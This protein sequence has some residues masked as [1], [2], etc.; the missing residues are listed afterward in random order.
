MSSAESVCRFAIFIPWGRVGSNL[1]MEII[2]QAGRAKLENEKFNTLRDEDGQMKWYSDF[3]E[4]GNHAPSKSIIGTKEN[5][6]AVANPGRMARTMLDDGIKIV[7]MRRD[8]HVKAAVSQ[9]R[10]QQYASLTGRWGVLKGEEGL[11]PTHIDPDDLLKRISS[12]EKAYDKLIGLF[13]D[14]AGSGHRI[15]GGQH[16][17]AGC[18]GKIVL[19]APDFRAR[20]FSHPFSKGDFRR[21]DVCDFQLCGGSR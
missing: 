21:L 1:I 7:R 3:Y 18:R 11:G 5:I 15:R 16:R 9:M 13:P 14:N 6:L 10:A 2:H 12:I 4:F 19:L 20:S 8:N 17:F